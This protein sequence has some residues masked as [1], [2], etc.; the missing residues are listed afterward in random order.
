MQYALRIISV[1]KSLHF[2]NTLII[3]YYYYFRHSIVLQTRKRL[4]RT[5]FIRTKQH[6]NCQGNPLY[7]ATK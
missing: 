7:Q 2:I 6:V 4:K 1:D 5:L 3:Y